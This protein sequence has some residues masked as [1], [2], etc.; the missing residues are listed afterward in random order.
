MPSVTVS[1]P[2]KDYAMCHSSLNLL[3]NSPEKNYSMLPYESKLWK[4]HELKRGH[5][6]EHVV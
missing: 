3:I 4:V 5:D 2:I 6:F 1:A